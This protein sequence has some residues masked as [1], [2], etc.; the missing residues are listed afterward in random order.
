MNERFEGV[1]AHALANVYFEG[2]VISH[3][4]LLANGKKVTLGLIYAGSYHFDTGAP[5]RMDITAGSCRVRLAGEQDFREYPAGTSF[6]VPGNSYFDI[7][8]DAGIAQY[9]CSFG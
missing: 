4:L 2:K 1:T 8:V 7:S 5:E 3:T 9:V 6:E